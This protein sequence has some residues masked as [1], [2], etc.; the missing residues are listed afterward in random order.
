MVVDHTAGLAQGQFVEYE[1]QVVDG[2]IP[3]EVSLC[4]T[5]FPGSPVAARQIVNN[6]N[7]TVSNGATVYKGSVFSA[8]NSTTGGVYDS[9]NVEEN[10]RVA[11]PATGVW[12]VRVSAPAVPMGPQPFALCVTG[13]VGNGA[14]ALALDRAEYGSA[15]TI[16]IQV[17][18]T[19][20]T[21][22]VEVSVVSPTEGTET[23]TLTGANGVWT[24][25]LPLTPASPVAADGALSVSNG[26][27][28]V[29]TYLDATTAVSLD[30]N[31][32][33]N[34]DTPI[35]T[36]VRATSLGVAGTLITWTTDR[37]ATSRV[38]FGTTGAL[39]LG[40]VDS[41]GYAISHAVVLTGLT[42]G[43]T[44]RYDV[45]SVSLSGSSARDDLGGAHHRFTTG[46]GG[47]VLL[48]MEDGSFPHRSI[49]EEAL[50]SLGYA[51]D[52]WDGALAE[53]P[54]VGNTASGMRAYKAVLWQ[55]GHTTYPPFSATQR[56]ALDSLLAGGA[57]LL[58]VGHDIGWGLADAAAP[59]F[60]SA[61][62]Q[63]LEQVLR[64]TYVSDPPTWNFEYGFAGD[65]ISN[66]WTG[67]L[68]YEPFGSGQAGDGI[69]ITPGITGTAAYVWKND[70][71]SVDTTALRWQ[72]AG[73]LG[74]PANATWGGQ[75][76]R[77][78]NYC[79]EWSRLLPPITGPDATRTEILGS[80]LAWL[81]GRTPPEV[82]VTAPNGGETVTTA[83][84]D[85]TW[86][87]SAA[88]G[89]TIAAR[90]IEY[91]LDGGDSWTTITTSPGASPYTW[92]LSGVPNSIAVLVRVRVTDDGTPALSGVDRSAAVFTLDRAAAD[93]TGPVVVAGSIQVTPN[94]LVRPGA[95]TVLAR[96]SDSGTG[97]A[98][99]TQ[100]EWSIGAAPAAAGTGT[101]LGSTFDSTTVNVSGALDLTSVFTGTRDVWVR[102]RDA[103]GNWGPASSLAV[104]V[105]GTDP[106]G[107]G[108]RPSVTFL[109]PAAPNPFAGP[110]T[111][112]FGLARGGD[113]ALDV[114]DAQGRR[115]RRLAGGAMAAGLHAVEWDGRDAAGGKAR[116]GVYM[117]RF[118]HPGGT[119]ER[120]I[121][122]LD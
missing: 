95:G 75:P 11:A 115:V 99:V 39:E 94:P 96:V 62:K 36:D 73:P 84:V 79:F 61:G 120:R 86:T 31:A 100:A 33:V 112:R 122:A 1:V 91:S 55:V 15:S 37:N 110:V 51:Y 103:A 92:D 50:T 119:I 13:G 78:V 74:S 88:G 17:I 82:A 87:E 16:E 85:V 7:L 57:R 66:A 34:F 47:D 48:V 59:G 56:T 97:G 102:A 2:S 5:D 101:A 104:L 113:V 63:W 54:A 4:W 26:D 107:V 14:G 105:N 49:W 80:T 83:T 22:P 98:I 108:D 89:F 64:T 68:T 69:R 19:D 76:S 12:T 25:T 81:L 32:T 117:V 77:L 72:S 93:A 8:G 20:A 21:D 3:L 38:H 106:V 71:F 53:N 109:A 23:V 24:G 10:V 121:V 118:A 52:V 40:S 60:T 41:T 65:P 114:F 111:L 90:S 42:P 45:E 6:L 46:G 70:D 35:I 29:A 43:Q 44:Y 28:L 30:A 67:G 18:D 9:L 116:P 58:T 27:A